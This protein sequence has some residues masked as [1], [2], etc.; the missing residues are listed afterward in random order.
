MKFKA[1]GNPDADTETEY[2]TSCQYK[3]LCAIRKGI[4]AFMLDKAHSWSVC[5]Q[6]GNPTRSNKVKELMKKV[7]EAEAKEVGAPSQA[8]GPFVCEE[9]KNIIQTFKSN[10]DTEEALFTSSIFCT[11]YNM[12]ARIDD[13][14]KQK[15]EHLKEPSSVEHQ[16]YCIRT[17][18]PWS[19]KVTTKKQALTHATAKRVFQSVKQAMI[20]SV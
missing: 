3:T 14:S 2:P 11:Q 15:S 6:E 16:N 20:K 10:E 17:K 12:G 7:E 9:Y 19:K 4:S 18:L 13:V 5:N 1:Y 8:R